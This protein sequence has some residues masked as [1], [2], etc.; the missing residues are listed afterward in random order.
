MCRSGLG[1]SRLGDTARKGRLGTLTMI[2]LLASFFVMDIGKIKYITGI[3][4][5][6]I[7]F[8]FGI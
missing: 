5:T 3:Y 2:L 1:H 7:S 6:L 4:A 8:D